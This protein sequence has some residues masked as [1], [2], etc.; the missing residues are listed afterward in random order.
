MRVVIFSDLHAHPHQEA[1][2]VDA[3]GRNTRLNDCL[4]ALQATTDAVVKYEAPFRLFCGDLFHSRGQIMAKAFNPVFAHFHGVH[5]TY[6]FT[7]ILIPGNHD[8]EARA[9]GEVSIQSLGSIDRVYVEIGYGVHLWETPAIENKALLV[10]W[11][12]HHPDVN[13]IK[14]RL[15]AV[16]QH[17]DACQME[18]HKILLLHHGVDGTLPTIPDCGLAPEDLPT[19][20][21]DWTF[22]GDYHQYKELV[23]GKA[24]SVGT[25]LQHHFGDVGKTCGYL[26][27]DTATGKVEQHEIKGL[28]RFHKVQIQGGAPASWHGDIV[29]GDFVAIEAD[30]ETHL[31]NAVEVIGNMVKAKVLRAEYVPP[32]NMGH[33]KVEDALTMALDPR[34]LFETWLAAQTDLTDEDKA[35]LRATNDDVLANI[36]V[37][38]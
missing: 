2:S 10:G 31:Q 30:D 38:A 33:L 3:N 35:E 37:A 23:P 1:S 25:P 29:E 8:R 13:V 20:H 36:K 12:C 16:A 15:R 34:A 7:D 18:A 26:L 21:F 22:V 24:W 19:D 17:A 14:A 6:Q 28:P 11:V 27:L 4:T 9:D 32:G 5:G